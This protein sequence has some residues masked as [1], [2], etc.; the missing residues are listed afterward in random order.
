MQLTLPRGVGFAPIAV[1]RSTNFDAAKR[2]ALRHYCIPRRVTIAKL[3]GFLPQATIELFE[4][5]EKSC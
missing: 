2:T 1:V 3:E 5:V 4:C